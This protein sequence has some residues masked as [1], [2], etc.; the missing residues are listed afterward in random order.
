M[1][2]PRRCIDWKGGVA[3]GRVGNQTSEIGKA[4]ETARRQ[5]SGHRSCIN[6][7]LTRL[8]KAAPRKRYGAQCSTRCSPRASPCPTWWTRP[9][10]KISPIERMQRIRG[11]QLDPSRLSAAAVE[12]WSRSV[13]LA[14]LRLHPG[15]GTTIRLPSGGSRWSRL[16]STLPDTGSIPLYVTVA[17]PF[18]RFA[19]RADLGADVLAKLR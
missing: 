10:S 8:P 14:L 13:D 7:R 9:C 4:I 3:S 1:N 17:M 15:L 19:V 11:R 5:Q 18:A 16:S 2:I 12:G 6:S